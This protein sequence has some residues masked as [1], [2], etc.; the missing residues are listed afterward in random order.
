MGYKHYYVNKNA[1]S[2]GDYEVHSE[3]CA[4]IPAVYNRDYLGYFNDCVPAVEQ[5][6]AKGYLKANGCY[7]CSYKCHTS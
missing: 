7:W 3:D 1:Q 2:N 4:W 6:R 5:A